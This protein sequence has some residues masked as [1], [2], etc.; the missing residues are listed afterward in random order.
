MHESSLVRSLL[1]QVDE[2]ST[3]NGSG[4]V[5]EVHVEIGP[6]SGVESTLLS[7]AFDRIRG[8]WAACAGARLCIDEVPLEARCSACGNTFHPAKFDFHCAV[9]GN[10]DTEIVRGDGVLLQSIVLDECERGASV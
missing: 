5:R 8:D 2:L 7:A 6:L 9:C 3:L 10:G 1:A 4:F